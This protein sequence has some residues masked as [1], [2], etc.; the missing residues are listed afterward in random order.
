MDVNVGKIVRIMGLQDGM[1]DY[2]GLE[3]ER[4]LINKDLRFRN[5]SDYGLLGINATWKRR[6]TNCA[7]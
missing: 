6:L 4:L 3:A 2:G 1:S 7:D 5:R